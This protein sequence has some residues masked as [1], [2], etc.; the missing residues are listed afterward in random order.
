[1]VR[2][3][4]GLL[5][6]TT[7]N[8]GNLYRLATNR[9]GSG[10]YV[11]EVHDA[12][13]V[14]TWG[15][16]PLAGGHAGRQ[17]PCACRPVPATPPCPATPGA[18]GPSP[19]PRPGGD[20]HQQPPTRAIWQWR[21]SL[22]GDGATPALF[23]VTAAYLPRN[24]APQVTRITVHPPGRVNLR[25]FPHRFRRFAGLGRRA[26]PP[27]RRR[28]RPPRP[29]RRTLGRQ[30]YRKGLQSFAWDARDP[31]RRS[32]GVRGPLPRGNGL[33]LARAE[34][35]ELTTRLFTWDTTSTPDGTYVVRI[36]A[37][38]AAA[39]APGRELTAMR[40]TPPFDVDNSPR[41]SRWKA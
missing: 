16:H 40:D 27:L 33:G 7:A 9:A 31:E 23:S 20:R 21:A 2:G 34:A 22:A 6:Y 26:R 13:T 3:P 8:P 29:R 1:M 14:A 11:S 41:G 30:V 36:V 18:G 15:H 37:T 10:T 38:D 17:F 4:D 24:L 5:Y 32:P 25:S 35:R 19:M 28:P 39:N 12:R